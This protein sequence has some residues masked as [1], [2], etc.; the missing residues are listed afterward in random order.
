[1]QGGLLDL[2][3]RPGDD[4]EVVRVAR[5]DDAHPFDQPLPS[6]F[7]AWDLD[8]LEDALDASVFP[9]LDRVDFD[10]FAM[11]IPSFLIGRIE[12]GC[13]EATASPRHAVLWPQESEKP[14]RRGWSC[15][16]WSGRR[17]GILEPLFAA[18]EALVT[19][20]R[21]RLR[22]GIWLCRA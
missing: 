14:T 6:V 17:H 15:R 7:P 18:L 9:A 13:T 19:G 2:R 10:G 1:M 16:G 12:C 4:K 20:R 21:S 3:P 8:D 11:G 5:I 22:P